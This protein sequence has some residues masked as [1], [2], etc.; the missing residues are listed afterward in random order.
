MD[1]LNKLS[2]KIFLVAYGL[3][4][5]MHAY[6]DINSVGVVPP[7]NSDVS[8]QAINRI[9]GLSDELREFSVLSEAIGI[10]NSSMMFLGSILVGYILI[11]GVLKTAQEGTALGQ[12]W[13]TLMIPFRASVGLAMTAPI[14]GGYCTVQIIALWFAIQGVGLA[15]MVWSGAVDKIVQ[16]N[17]FVVAP[18]MHSEAKDIHRDLYVT[19]MCEAS[20]NKHLARLEELEMSEYPAGTRI[21]FREYGN[22]ADLGM[23]S[24]TSSNTFGYTV[25]A[26][27]TSLAPDFCGKYWWGSFNLLAANYQAETA[28]GSTVGNAID[29]VVGNVGNAGKWNGD[30]VSGFGGVFSAVGQNATNLWN[31]EAHKAGRD[32]I[33]IQRSALRRAYNGHLVNATAY[34]ETG[35][36]PSV[37][38]VMVLMQEYLNDIGRSNN[39]VAGF[40]DKQK[41]GTFAEDAK[42]DGWALA[43]SYYSRIG[44]LNAAANEMVK[45][46][47]QISND[48]K[49]FESEADQEAYGTVSTDIDTARNQINKILY[50]ILPGTEK[51]INSMKQGTMYDWEADKLRRSNGV[52]KEEEGNSPLGW[53][54]A[55]TMT[56]SK[57]VTDLILR[58]DMDPM[59]RT[60]NIGHALLDTAWATS[61]AFWNLKKFTKQSQTKEQKEEASND[62]EDKKG[63]GAATALISFI[64][65]IW[66]GLLFL[67]A[68]MAYVFPMIPYIIM[69][70]SVLSWFT[71]IFIAVI[72]SPLWAISH[73]TP[74]G[75]EAFGSGSNGYILLMSVVLRPPLTILAMFG[76]MAI[77]WG[78]DLVFK[79]GFQ[80]AFFGGQMNSGTGVV[81]FFAYIFMY[82]AL[83]MYLVY[84]CYRLVQ[85]VPNAVLGWIGGRD[86]DSIGVESHNDKVYG[87]MVMARNV[88][89]AVDG[90]KRTLQATKGGGG[91]QSGGAGASG[92][93][94]GGPEREREQSSFKT[95]A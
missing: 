51:D 18:S 92:R 26:N 67:G 77:L 56:M 1:L 84:G 31:V 48:K 17:G 75:H 60:Q 73:A 87:A 57:E 36:P 59:S 70:F 63:G 80:H 15:D 89:G 61:T 78:I 22:P 54:Q 25:G 34:L 71:S 52:Y 33:D 9:F 83:S 14:I 46:V 29:G 2:T 41:L 3:F 32:L 65:T 20:M 35:E 44:H 39:V 40:I 55:P 6:A 42:Q 62:S 24:G 79:V 5:S 72:A 64:D 13:N 10:W 37:N 28:T 58:E 12:R 43:G 7:P 68:I 53:I 88:G 47:P 11:V 76:S 81:A 30:N 19:A 49:P 94:R 95:N 23:V 90:A 16:N 82:C 69:L 86:D 93:G 50:E 4:L 66:L 85:T 74:D 91:P 45:A 21:G 27:N 8:L 38:S